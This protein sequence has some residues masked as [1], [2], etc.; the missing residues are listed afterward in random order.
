MLNPLN[1]LKNTRA[2]RR[3]NTLAASCVFAAA[4]SFAGLFLM[5]PLTAGRNFEPPEIIN[6]FR[7]NIRPDAAQ[8]P[9]PPETFPVSLKGQTP[10]SKYIIS[11]S[12]SIPA[13]TKVPC[14]L[15]RTDSNAAGLT[16]EALPGGTL[17]LYTRAAGQ[18]GE[19]KLLAVPDAFQP[20]NL[21][22]GSI[23]KNKNDAIILRVDNRGE[24][25]ATVHLP[26]AIDT[27]TVG[28]K[29]GA[30]AVIGLELLFTQ[31]KKSAQA[32]KLPGRLI[33]LATGVLWLILPLALIC[34]AAQTAG[35]LASPGPLRP[36][37]SARRAE[38]IGLLLMAGFVCATA[39]HYIEGGYHN[40]PYPLS[41]FL[42]RPDDVLQD[43]FHHI[44]YAKDLNPYLAKTGIEPSTYFPF[45]YLPLYP[46]AHT[47]K[48]F[49]R[50]C[51]FAALP[52]F[53][54]LNIKYLKRAGLAHVA[55]WRNAL[56]YSGLSYPLLFCMD[57]GNLEIFVFIAI[58]AAMFLLEK[59]KP[60]TASVF[61]ALAIA[62]KGYPAIFLLLFIKRRNWNAALLACGISAAL[63]AV[64]LLLYKGG[65]MENLA[66]L[67][68]GIEFVA[69]RYALDSYGYD[70]NA[71]LFNP[72]RIGASLLYGMQDRAALLR[73]FNMVAF[74]AGCGVAYYVLRRETVLW[75]QA[76]LLVC[77]EVL[78][79]P[80]SGAYKLLA[81][82]VPMWLF[83]N[84]PRR[85]RFDNLYAVIFALLLIPKEYPLFHAE[86]LPPV[87]ISAVLNPLLMALLCALIIMDRQQAPAGA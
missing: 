75:K 16:L 68:Q 34:L 67:W 11:F 66:G 3:I 50:L 5:Y 35:R 73:V 20:G 83:I 82:F 56:V 27:I 81:F 65:F 87:A 59:D 18:P 76:A 24:K 48:D 26:A 86:P 45:V 53:A 55:L 44:S 32:Q 85:S 58:A 25:V 78:A 33:I 69:R 14:R 9:L 61:L 63:T 30:A 60:L 12:A 38:L 41:T 28:D 72:L 40:N 57:R 80:F 84:A 54:W 42:F 46:L 1:S 49:M 10:A 22:T 71:S 4:L 43:L 37:E 52:L 7:G 2:G 36:D 47:G 39:F 23:T 79:T 31:F 62:A 77:Y 6:I 13:D 8:T 17:A 29:T 19:K 74:A 15:V 51:F 21:F 70:H 64:P